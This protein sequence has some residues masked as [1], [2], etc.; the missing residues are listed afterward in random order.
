[1]TNDNDGNG[2]FLNENGD[3]MMNLVKQKL[4][5]FFFLIS[6]MDCSST[7]LHC[8]QKLRILN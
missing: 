5:T 8:V 4:F 7:E 2:D 1:M 3:V 6:M